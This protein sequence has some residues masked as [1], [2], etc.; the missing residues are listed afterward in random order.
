MSI[1]EER[2][3]LTEN[4]VSSMIAAQRGL[5]TTSTGPGEVP[6]AAQSQHRQYQQHSAGNGITPSVQKRIEE[7][8]ERTAQLHKSVV[9][10]SYAADSLHDQFTSSNHTYDE[11]E[12]G[13]EQEEYGAEG[14]DED[15]L[16]LYE[17]GEEDEEE[18]EEAGQFDE[19]DEDEQD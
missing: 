17:A 7:A 8:V 13:E 10:V 5:D 11:E 2:L 16:D 6:S 18:P 19:S 4:R 3:S 12:E 1:M 15:A 14:E 9:N